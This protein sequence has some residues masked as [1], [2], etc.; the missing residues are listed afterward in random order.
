M[1]RN[2]VYN[3]TMLCNNNT[4]KLLY[5]KHLMSRKKTKSF[6]L[7]DIISCQQYV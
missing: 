6:F 2:R 1:P 7:S 5:S 3:I 4:R